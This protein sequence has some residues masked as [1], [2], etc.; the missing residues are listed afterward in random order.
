[1]AASSNLEATLFPN[2][3]TPL[4]VDGFPDNSPDIS[5]AE[6]E[7][8]EHTYRHLNSLSSIRH[9]PCRSGPNFKALILGPPLSYPP[10]WS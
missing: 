8:I 7:A 5:T 10:S 1:M 9:H 2:I 3:D 6:F 4:F